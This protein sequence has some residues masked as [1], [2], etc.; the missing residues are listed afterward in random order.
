MSH[1][2]Y[3]AIALGSDSSNDRLSVVVLQPAGRPLRV[4]VDANNDKRITEEE[5]ADLT[6]DAV[7]FPPC[8]GRLSALMPIGIGLKQGNHVRLD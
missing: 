4:Y 8:K 2:L 1:V 7:D 3:T 5:G 6:K